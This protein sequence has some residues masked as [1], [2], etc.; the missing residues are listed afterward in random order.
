M[1]YVPFFGWFFKSPKPVIISE[2]NHDTESG[3]STVVE[4]SSEQG[5]NTEDESKNEEA[6]DLGQSNP[7]DKDMYSTRS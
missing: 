3:D 1:S 6:E 7:E 5:K 2:A 4:E